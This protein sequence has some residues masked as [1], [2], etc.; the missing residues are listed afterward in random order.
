[1]DTRW[2]TLEGGRG[3]GA[4]VV[5]VSGASQP[6]RLWHPAPCPPQWATAEAMA[7]GP[8]PTPV[9]WETEQTW[10]QS[11]GRVTFV[12][13]VWTCVLVPSTVTSVA[14]APAQVLGQL[15]GWRG[16]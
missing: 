12:C 6:Q 10:R 5:P 7:P 4:Q 8:V 9:A 14:T 2:V 15:A 3:W 13:S 1:M 11:L 16:G